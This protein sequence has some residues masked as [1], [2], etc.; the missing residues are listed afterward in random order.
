MSEEERKQS[1]AE[2]DDPDE[3]S[4]AVDSV[5]GL[6]HLGENTIIEEGCAMHGSKEIAI[7]SHVFVRTGA[8][9]NICT[10]VTGER[11]KIIIG[12]YCQFNKSVLLSAA[13]RIRIERFAMIGPHSF[14]MDTQHE[15]RHIG[16]PI[17]MQGI[18]ETEG[19]TIIGESTWVGANCVI[20][21]PLTI[22]RGS[23]IGG[24]S[25]VTRDIPDYCVAVGSPARV[26]K[27]FDTDTADWIAVKSK[28]DV[29]AVMRRRRE[30]P[31]LSIC[32]PTYNRAA[33][34]N[35][36]LQTI[37]HQIGDC[38]LF[39]VVV[40]DN[41]SPDGTQQVLAA[42][43]EVYP[44][45]NLRYW[46]NDENI[47]AERNIIKLLDDARG[48]YVLL[49]GDDDFFT[50]LTIMP[51]LNLIQMNRDCS[52][53]FLNVLNDDGRVHRMEGLSTFIETASLHSGFISS[54]MIQREAYRQVEDKT[55]FIG[56][57]FNHI[58]LQLEAL[59]YNPH[60]AVVNKAMFGYAGNKPTGYNFGKFFIDG[61]L[62]I[63]DHYRS[64]GL[65]DE[66]LLKEKR[67]MLATTVLPWYKRIVEEQLGADISGFEEIYTAHY[68]DEPYFKAILEW[69]RNIKPLTKESQE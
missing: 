62:S 63:L 6:Y 11:P 13:N 20:S 50:D 52:V 68:K 53:F 16:I 7:G 25:V 56:S 4:V 49:H 5:R 67:T 38:S 42:F 58:Y 64:Y 3:E 30:R 36:C 31:V 26:I 29:A 18:T 41:A 66:A 40:S 19:A 57:G 54:V 35:R 2:G 28:E 14:I 27:M 8:W 22:G 12:D 10:D 46:R 61:Y 47:G 65:S 21:G 15:Y 1:G 60:F 9:F 48:D 51:M 34:L 17:S 45:M 69:I 23:V 24:N 37:V 44:N 55:K 59:R 43:A 32:I 33:D 39:E